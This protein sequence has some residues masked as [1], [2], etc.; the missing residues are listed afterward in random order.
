VPVYNLADF[1]A[2]SYTNA[3]VT[4]RSGVKGNLASGSLWNGF[5]LTMTNPS[6][7]LMTV[8]G[9]LQGNT[10]FLNAWRASS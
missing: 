4:S 3:A 2:Q 9:S 6:G 8:L 7:A 10:A 5:A 1:G